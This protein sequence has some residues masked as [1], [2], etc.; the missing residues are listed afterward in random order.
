MSFWRDW[1][2][3]FETKNPAW[4]GQRGPKVV[5]ASSDQALIRCPLLTH[6]CVRV[7]WLTLVTGNFESVYLGAEREAC[8]LPMKTKY[9]IQMSWMCSDVWSINFGQ[10]TLLDELIVK[11]CKRNL[12]GKW[13]QNDFDCGLKELHASSLNE[14]SKGLW[15]QSALMWAASTAANQFRASVLESVFVDFSDMTCVLISFVFGR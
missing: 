8:S 9:W 12:S 1:G 14:Q 15:R 3:G 11:L 6:I 2:G 5:C 13:C 4:C 7:V 10:Y